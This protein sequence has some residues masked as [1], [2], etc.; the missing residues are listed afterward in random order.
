MKLR[1]PRPWTKEEKDLHYKIVQSMKFSFELEDF[2]RDKNITLEEMASVMGIMPASL[3]DIFSGN[4]LATKAMANAVEKKYGIF[5]GSNL[6][7]QCSFC[8]KELP[9][10]IVVQICD[11]CVKLGD[12]ITE[13]DEIRHFRIKKDGTGYDPIGIEEGEKRAKEEHEKTKDIYN[14]TKE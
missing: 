2:M 12:P 13:S 4:V 8:Y 3:E 7:N 11:E 9:S 14:T 10:D 5:F 1:I 6:S